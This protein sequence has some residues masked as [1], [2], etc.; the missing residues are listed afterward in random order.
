MKRRKFITVLTGAAA[1]P[2]AARA[3]PRSVRRVGVIS[4]IS[5]NDPEAKKRLTAFQQGLEQLGWNAG[6][7]IRLDF[8]WTKK[9]SVRPSSSVERPITLRPPVAAGAVAAV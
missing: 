2:L 6:R 9:P 5:E 4:T 3:Q 8:S 7:N 1:W